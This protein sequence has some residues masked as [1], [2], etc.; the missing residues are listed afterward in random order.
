MQDPTPLSK[1]VRAFAGGWP[2]EGRVGELLNGIT[3][4][5][6]HQGPAAID[7]AAVSV[8]LLRSITTALYDQSIRHRLNRLLLRF[9]TSGTRVARGGA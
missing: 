4:S 3:I 8:V 9:K 1:D 6:V 5:C 2:R 7:N